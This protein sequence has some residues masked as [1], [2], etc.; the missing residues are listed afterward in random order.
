LWRNGLG[1]GTLASPSVSETNSPVLSKR[2]TPRLGSQ[3]YPKLTVLLMQA[4]G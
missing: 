2:A 3:G 1:L 4:P